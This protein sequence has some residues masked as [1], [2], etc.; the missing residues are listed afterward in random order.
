MNL[1]RG[2][3]LVVL[4]VMLNF[5]LVLAINWEDYRYTGLG[6]T[7]NVDDLDCKEWP[8]TS[9]VGGV[10]TADSWKIYAC[11]N[12]V[13]N[14]V[15]TV[16]FNDNLEG[17]IYTS[18]E[19]EMQPW[20]DECGYN[21]ISVG[22]IISQEGTDIEDENYVKVYGV[23]DWAPLFSC[24]IAI[25]SGGIADRSDTNYEFLCGQDDYWYERSEFTVNEVLEIGLA[26][27][28]QKLPYTC[29]EVNGKYNW[30]SKLDTTTDSDD[31]GVPDSLDCAPTNDQV[32]GAFI[33]NTVN[34]P[35]GAS[36]ICSDGLDNDCS[37]WNGLS[38]YDYQAN[39]DADCDLDQ[40]ACEEGGFD[41]EEGYSCCGDDG[42]EDFG[43]GGD[44]AEG[45]GSLC[46]ND[47]YLIGQT[48]ISQ[49]GGEAS[50][51]G[52]AWV[53]ASSPQA[54]FKILNIDRS[55]LGQSKDD[56]ISNGEEWI[57]CGP[58][59]SALSSNIEFQRDANKFYCYEEG[60]SWSWAECD[61][62]FDELINS[63]LQ[64]VRQPGDS[65]YTLNFPSDL[66][67]A[68]LSGQDQGKKIVSLKSAD[69][70]QDFFDFTSYEY[71][72]FW[73]ELVDQ[74]GQPVDLEKINLPADIILTFTLPG[75]IEFSR[76]IL[77]EG[78]K[79]E[80]EK[81]II[82]NNQLNG[83]NKIHLQVDIS[84]IPIVESLS[85]V[86]TS[87]NYFKIS[88]ISVIK[89]DAGQNLYCSG[90]SSQDKNV[91]INS[92][93]Y[94]GTAQL[95]AQLMCNQVYGSE[96]WSED[97]G[98]CGNNPS[99]DF[100]TYSGQ[101]CWKGTIV[102]NDEALME[103]RF[104]VEYSEL[105]INTA[106]AVVDFDYTVEAE[107]AVS[108]EDKVKYA[109]PT[110]IPNNII[111]KTFSAQTSLNNIYS[112]NLPKE[113]FPLTLP[114]LWGEGNFNFNYQLTK[115]SVT[116]NS[117]DVK[118]SLFNTQEG[119]FQVGT[120]SEANS[121]FNNLRI[122]AQTNKIIGGS[123]Y[124]DQ[125]KVTIFSTCKVGSSSSCLFSLPYSNSYRITNPYPQLYSLWFVG[126]EGKEVPVIDG[127]EIISK[128]GNIIA[129]NV[130]P[131]ILFYGSEEGDNHLFY[132]CQLPEEITSQLSKDT[133]SNIFES[134]NYCSTQ[135]SWF[136]AY[137]SGSAVNSWSRES[138]EYIGY[139]IDSNEKVLGSKFDLE[140]VEEG[141]ETYSAGNR[142]Q[143]TTVLPGRNIISNAEFATQAGVLVH[144]DFSG[145]DLSPQ[146]NAETKTINLN[147]GESII[148]TR[149]AVAVPKGQNSAQYH[150]SQ[151]GNCPAEIYT[152]NKDGIIT[153]VSSSNFKKITI[154]P[155]TVYLTVAFNS[156]ASGCTVYHPL[157][158]LLDPQYSTNPN[159]GP[160]N[161]HYA[162]SNP[163]KFNF[164]AGVA[165][166]QVNGCWNGYA[167]V[168][169]MSEY[170][171]MSEQVGENEGSRDYRCVEGKWED[172]PAKKD[173]NEDQSGFCSQPEQCFVLSSLIE[174][175]SSSN[176]AKEF[177]QGKF[178]VCIND[179]EFILDH[180]CDQ[181][182]WT[183]RTKFIAQKMLEL[184][185]NKNDYTIYCTDLREALTLTEEMQTS[186]VGDTTISPKLISPLGNKPSAQVCYGGIQSLT[187][188]TVKSV[189]PKSGEG[190]TPLVSVK[191]NT[192]IN[193]VCLLKN[194]DGKIS[195]ATT[196]NENVDLPSGVIDVNARF[197]DLLGIP[198]LTTECAACKE[199]QEFI[200][201]ESESLPSG[202]K[203]GYSPKYKA[204]LY[205]LDVEPSILS[206]AWGSITDMF[207]DL[208]AGAGGLS[209]QDTFIQEV[210]NVKDIYLAKSGSKQVQ[211]IREIQGLSQSKQALIV[212][213]EGFST[214]ICDY[215]HSKKIAQE[216]IQ[217]ELLEDVTDQVKV[218]CGV[219]DSVQRVEAVSGL[220]FLWP[221]L[222]GKLRMDLG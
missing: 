80:E 12:T 220:N 72:D 26:D 112:V 201:C 211:G 56:I 6:T 10:Q 23:G 193:N 161:Y 185:G 29:L 169:E 136:C 51:S 21:S 155:D 119:V 153:K 100:F 37:N 24:N 42:L 137:S 204:V 157:L 59:I 75:E 1:K 184:V 175:V 199:E 44:F 104:E 177:Y 17:C 68:G 116:S 78:V 166:C 106:P 47:N 45:Q 197:F 25:K 65:V 18:S 150:F 139:D 22:T 219:D 115:I 125:D 174:G 71:F 126:E 123:A 179:G 128:G 143:P 20:G 27:S 3:I 55:L 165:C 215:V 141:D 209:N 207:A 202:I 38:G 14:P 200:D 191:E 48:T 111:T 69:L 213:Y 178:P 129:R 66:P 122:V 168:R 99:G 221:E 145:T 85:F 151:E 146:I 160:V 64:T 152:A 206:K 180:Y 163:D 183:S 187:G 53:P 156:A 186:L 39:G 192:C 62:N 101:G 158:Q 96:S 8:K 172:I 170:T 103:V 190:S 52:W 50:V 167:C 208:A 58:G 135:G 189:N 138:L 95:N 79:A 70:G 4:T 149:I 49:L 46:L 7:Q 93:D 159:L 15:G 107:Y 87:E 9:S 13:G 84:G 131:Q 86:S 162:E 218:S 124:Q 140:P 31:D 74:E 216:N 63:N 108:E 83:P 142:N 121:N 173:W 61:D 217:S 92:F 154:T 196:L 36:E 11:D 210:K 130:A 181:G 32:F 35:Q 194:K 67:D 2:L 77:A 76:N 176:T 98:C 88:D 133:N 198:D 117:E 90:K 109:L 40:S 34:S 110:D 60:N 203:L 28:T 118:L 33:G 43:R 148:S 171:F 16:N 113:D 164:R 182:E 81:E 41:F 105:K 188:D 120:N 102:K 82:I 195:F 94:L 214:P 89:S 132:G 30:V 54:H 222:T 97:N 114:L 91:W 73:I 205:N 212:E 134:V 19:E 57:S 5:S 144:W 147:P 127:Q